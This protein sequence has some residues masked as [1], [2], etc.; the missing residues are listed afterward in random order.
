MSDRLSHSHPAVGRRGR[1]RTKSPTLAEQAV[2][3]QLRLLSL[4]PALTAMVLLCAVW[5]LNVHAGASGE[6]MIALA[7][8]GCALVVLL[9]ERR[10]AAIA[11]YWRRRRAE[12]QAQVHAWL[13]HLESQITAGRKRLLATLDQ[14][15]RGERPSSPGPGPVLGKSG[16]PFIDFGHSLQ[17]AH[18]EAL[19]AVLQAASHQQ[20]ATEPGPQRL[21]VFLY[22]AQR[23]HALVTRAIAAIVALEK[24]VEDP[25]LLNGLFGIDHLITQTRRQVESLAVLGGA[26]PRRIGKPVLLATVLRQ[27][28]AEIE[29]FARVRVF[30]P[31][32]ATAIPG[33]AAPEVIHLLAELVENATR[34]SDPNT[35][36]LMRAAQ[37]PAGLVIEVEDR[38]L[39]MSPGTRAQ[40]NRLLAAPDEVDLREQLRDGRIGLLVTA[41]IAQRHNIR[42]ELRENLLGGTQALVV[43]PRPLLTVRAEATKP[44]AAMPRAAAVHAAEGSARTRGTTVPLPAEVP[45]APTHEQT[46]GSAASPAPSL[47][48]RP[49]AGTARSLPQ[50]RKHARPEPAIDAPV[51][52]GKPPLPRRSDSHQQPEPEVAASA[53]Q[54]D[55]PV[56]AP[57]AGLMATYA[58]GVKRGAQSDSTPAVHQDA[59]E[60][61]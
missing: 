44:K 11:E 30:V 26:V 61:G 59:T 51:P 54:R 60:T 16:D 25:V 39:P 58:E 19:D 29:D 4:V 13:Q 46:Q 42:V 35:Q 8:L 28:V 47:P 12:D 7:L 27:S 41:R 45:T 3:S 55:T 9:G 36:V 48:Q 20:Q 37:V 17:Q 40:M 15:E 2:P 32:E 14:I 34:F 31:Q 18:R 49:A 10:A 22:I 5:A 56:A 43:I 50:R 21:E 57:T 23:L 33:Y 38:G 1:R 24:D 6:W 52:N 53:P